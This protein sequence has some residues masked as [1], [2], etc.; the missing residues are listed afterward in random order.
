MMRTAGRMKQKG[1]G[2]TCA[3]VCAGGIAAY[4][5]TTQKQILT[6]CSLSA[7]RL[8]SNR[9]ALSMVIVNVFGIKVKQV[10]MKR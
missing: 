8:Q 2:N 10:L 9:A 1:L 7:V 4:K 3:T 5:A 6:I